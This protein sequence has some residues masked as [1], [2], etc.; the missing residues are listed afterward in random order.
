MKPLNI[1]ELLKVYV[2]GEE[3]SWHLE[4]SRYKEGKRVKICYVE[5]KGNGFTGM[6][7]TLTYKDTARY[8]G[9]ISMDSGG[10]GAQTGRPLFVRISDIVHCPR[11]SNGF[12]AFWPGNKIC[13]KCGFPGFKMLE[14]EI[15]F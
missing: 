3:I 8:Q 15:S 6:F 13:D 10:F 12:M 2:R 5:E 11:C 1:F 4:N 14:S 7:Y 9:R